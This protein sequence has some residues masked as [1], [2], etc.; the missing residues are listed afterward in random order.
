MPAKVSAI[1]LVDQMDHWR[2]SIGGGALA[3][4][5]RVDPNDTEDV[6]AFYRLLS[7]LTDDRANFPECSLRRS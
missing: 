6:R 5:E 4:T 7:R 2:I 3:W 1:D